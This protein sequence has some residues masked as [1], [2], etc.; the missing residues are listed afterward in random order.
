MNKRR[1]PLPGD[2]PLAAPVG[3]RVTRYAPASLP[4][5]PQHPPAAVPRAVPAVAEHQAARPA[6]T[7]GIGSLAG[8]LLAGIGLFFAPFAWALGRRAV[9]EIDASGG[10]LTGR[11]PA[12][13]GRILGII[14][15]CLLGVGIVAVLGLTVLGSLLT[16]SDA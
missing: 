11:G 4:G 13:A 5:G 9:Q 12:N 1:G 14:G 16:A 15:T 10:A 2:A 8:A 7:V 3:V 6:L